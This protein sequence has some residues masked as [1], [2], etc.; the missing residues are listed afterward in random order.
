MLKSVNK[1][2]NKPRLFHFCK[3]FKSNMEALWS[4]LYALGLCVYIA[5]SNMEPECISMFGEF[6]S[7]SKSFPFWERIIIFM[8]RVVFYCSSMFKLCLSRTCWF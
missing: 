1:D 4:T 7:E 5:L 8:L 3:G 6:L 2:V